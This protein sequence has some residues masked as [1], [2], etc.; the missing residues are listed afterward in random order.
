MHLLTLKRLTLHFT[1]PLVNVALKFY[2]GLAY[3]MQFQFLKVDTQS[4]QV[5]RV[6]TTFRYN[7]MRFRKVKLPSQ[8]HYMVYL[9]LSDPSYELE[10]IISH[11]DPTIYK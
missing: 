2:V 1:N 8:G 7:Q 11:S 9:R 5:C 10:R 4:I 6:C 3:F